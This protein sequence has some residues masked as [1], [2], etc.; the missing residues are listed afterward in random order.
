MK[1][2][3]RSGSRPSLHTKK[4]RKK[5]ANLQLGKTETVLTQLQKSFFNKKETSKDNYNKVVNKQEKEDNIIQTKT[6][7]PQNFITKKTKPKISVLYQ[8][9]EKETFFFL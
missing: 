7:Q 5:K 4:E 3:S 6:D 1:L 9:K 2:Q 8:E